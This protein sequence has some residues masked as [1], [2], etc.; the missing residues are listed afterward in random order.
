MS[1]V[2]NE[3]KEL[4]KQLFPTGRAW[5]YVHNSEQSGTEITNFVDGLGNQFVDGQGNAF[6][7]TSGSEASPS[8]RLINAFLKSIE[9]YYA[10]LLS[11][12][13]QILAD[14]DGFDITDASNWE[15]VYGLVA[16]SLTLDE[17]KQNIVLKQSYPNGNLERSSAEF[18]QDELQKHGFDV[19]I[20][21]NR[22]PDGS[23]GWLT[24]D[25]TAAIY[26]GF[27]YGGALYGNVGITNI[28]KIAN[29]IEESID[30]NFDMGT[31]VNLRA[32][33]F[34]GGAAYP[35]RANVPILRKDEF[36]QLI[37]K[38]KPNHT[39]G[40]LLIDYV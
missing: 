7:Q 6:I 26:G 18:I 34:L 22:F 19:Y 8:K 3:I 5:G 38:L 27:N 32:T 29:R 23:G 20:H 30:A 36:R 17:R 39:A 12:L 9:R 13:D 15:R 14:N 11:L 31:G 25:A 24:V 16:G 35:T 10:D 40:W 1:E 2:D 21:E 28:T 37:L 4:N 33:F